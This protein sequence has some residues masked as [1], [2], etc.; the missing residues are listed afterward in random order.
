[1]ARSV[2]PAHVFL[3]WLGRP[4]SL[5]ILFIRRKKTKHIARRRIC[6]EQAGLF[7]PLP[8][9]VHG[10]I[11]LH[12]RNAAVNGCSHYIMIPNHRTPRFITVTASRIHRRRSQHPLVFGPRPVRRSCTAHL[13]SRSGR[14]SF[15]R[16]RHSG[17][18]AV[19][20]TPRY[21]GT[22][23]LISMNVWNVF[24]V[25]IPGI[26]IAIAFANLSKMR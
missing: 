15:V 25:L 3:S 2:A 1:M 21:P 5:V 10:R 9:A 22:G 23:G 19:F 12:P 26:V 18:W 24:A 16:T 6:D 8:C 17:R 11:L 13:G 7:F 4:R 14:L 20:A